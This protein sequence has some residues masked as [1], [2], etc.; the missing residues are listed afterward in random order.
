[1]IG[2]LVDALS[3][4]NFS[5]QVQDS[6][7]GSAIRRICEAYSTPVPTVTLSASPTSISLGNFTTLTWASTGDADCSGNFGLIVQNGQSAGYS[8]DDGHQHLLGLGV[9]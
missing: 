8:D 3:H 4:G 9:Q 2:H 7:T 6:A 1:M 5:A